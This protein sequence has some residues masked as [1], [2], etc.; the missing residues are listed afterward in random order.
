M[1]GATAT[2]LALYFGDAYLSNSFC[3]LS[4]VVWTR[5]EIMSPLQL[6]TF[7][8]SVQLGCHSKNFTLV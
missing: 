8:T 2:A 5:V 6:V 4:V 3:D 7:F 1:F